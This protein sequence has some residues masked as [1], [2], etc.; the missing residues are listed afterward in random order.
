M[1]AIKTGQR[2]PRTSIEKGRGTVLLVATLAIALLVT[3]ASLLGLLAS[4]PYQGETGNWILQARGQDVGN[5]LAVITLI[6]SAFRMRAGSRGA[7]L[8]WTGTLLYLVYAYI[9]YAFALHF[10][11]LFLVYVAILGL[12]CY[13]LIAALSL[14]TG[15]SAYPRGAVRAFAAWTLIGTGAIFALLWLSELIPAT[16]VGQAPPSLQAAGLVVNPVHVVDLAVVLP[17]MIV[18]GVLT[19]RG[20]GTGL[21]LA[22]PALVFSV[23]MGTSIIAATVLIVASGDTSGFAPMTMVSAVVLVSLGAVISYVR[24]MPRRPPPSA[25]RR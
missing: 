6:V 11:R 8:I 12:V 5:L 25:T 20:R 24:R 18:I 15:P 7:G 4:W 14:D 21:S 10:G 23:L 16:V 17:G 22:V 3:A 9:V 13:T 19:L 1:M 2:R